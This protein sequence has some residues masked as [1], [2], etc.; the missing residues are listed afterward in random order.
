MKKLHRY[1]AYDNPHY[2]NVMYYTQIEGDKYVGVEYSIGM[3]GNEYWQGTFYDT[4][5]SLEMDDMDDANIV[6]MEGHEREVISHIL[7]FVFGAEPRY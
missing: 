6:V 4:L 3:S 2:K 5:D 7:N 1:F